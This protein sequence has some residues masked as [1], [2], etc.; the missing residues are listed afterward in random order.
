[1]MIFLTVLKFIGITLLSVLGLVLFLLLLVL[2]VPFRYSID[3]SFDKSPLQYEAIAGVSWLL[4]FIRFRIEFSKKNG[5]DYCVK[6]IG[7]RVFPK[8]DDEDHQGEVS[9]DE[10][11]ENT[12]EGLSQEAEMETHESE[13][14]E[15]AGAEA[16]EETVQTTEEADESPSDEGD[17]GHT[18]IFE[19]AETQGR[20]GCDEDYRVGRER[21]FDE[22]GNA[23]GT[24]D[25]GN[26]RK[27]GNSSKIKR[28]VESVKGIVEKI[29][30]AFENISYTTERV[31]DKINSAIEK[32]EY[33]K[34]WSEEPSTRAAFAK[35][36]AQLRFLLKKIRPKK[37][38]LLV[39]FGHEDPAETGKIYGDYAAVSPWIG[40]YLLLRPDFEKDVLKCTLTA[41]GYI[42]IYVLLII[43]C[44]LFFDKNLRRAYR[45]FKRTA[46]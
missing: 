3:G 17:E 13:T 24:D 44:K 36:F 30:A 41:K 8:K 20:E 37:F 23:F 15:V 40:K 21:S 46:R 2:F 39:D 6:I 35:V 43:A 4:R 33:Y 9:Y 45:R 29:K 19:E 38:K 18:R 16:K 14:G 1:M 26:H 34:K 12:Y 42:Q 25:F 27:D 11:Y 5:L 31:C 28:F 22:D 7:I 10:L 32:A